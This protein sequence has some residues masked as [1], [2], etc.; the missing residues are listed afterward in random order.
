MKKVLMIAVMWLPVVAMA[1]NDWEVPDKV[2]TTTTS[3]TGTTTAAAIPNPD[4]KYLTGAVPVKDGKVV[5]E[6][7]INAPGKSADQ[8]YDILLD[9][10]ERMARG[11]N[12]SE[13][14]RV[15]IQDK[16]KH[17]IVA[18]F[19]EWLV[20]TNKAL[21]LDRTHLRFYLIINCEDG[22]ATAEMTRISYLY[23]EERDPQRY[24][25]E[26]WITD[27]EC[28]NKEHTKLF[29][30]NGKFRRKTIDRKDFIFNKLEEELNK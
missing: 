27:E 8:I 15:V 16:A 20:F 22:K 23:E 2:E 5:F 4:A 25:A 13:Q 7:T 9:L 6:Q 28:M 1:Q 24:T 17:Q 29:R 12:Q 11:G 26:E 10:V 30:M 14:S 21:V 19:Y 18:D 3:T